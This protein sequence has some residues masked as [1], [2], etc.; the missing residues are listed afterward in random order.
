[1]NIFDYIPILCFL[2]KVLSY[3]FNEYIFKF[4][5]SLDAYNQNINF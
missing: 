4:M 1:M 3:C 2:I 5:L